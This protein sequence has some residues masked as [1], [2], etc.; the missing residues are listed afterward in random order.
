MLFRRD[1]LNFDID[2]L[3]FVTRLA[4]TVVLGISEMK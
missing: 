3:K 2:I 1:I 4:Y